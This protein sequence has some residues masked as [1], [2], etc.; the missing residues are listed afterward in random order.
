MRRAEP[1]SA[2]L[3]VMA[4]VGFGIG[5]PLSRVAADL[6][7]NAATITFWRAATSVIALALLLGVGVLLRRT[8]TT[9]WASISRLE[10][11]QLVA[12]GV[13][14][15]GTTLG[16]YTALERISVALAYILFYTYPTIVALAAVRLYG[17]P[18]PPARLAAISMATLGMVLVV[19]A[20][21][22]DGARAGVDVVGILLAFGAGLCQAGYAL[23]AARGFASVPTF[24][25]STLLRAFSVVVYAVLL[26][27]LILALGDLDKL[28]GPLGS[29]EA[30][31]VVGVAGLVTAALPTT[32]LVAGY[33]RVGPTR[34]AVLMLFEPLVGVLLAAV[35]LAEQPTPL[36]LVGGLMV[37]V[38]GAVVQVTASR[39]TVETVALSAD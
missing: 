16:I 23:V 25:A 35:W 27:P 29:P 12:M 8:N 4:A 17:E 37:L 7:F 36:Q 24:Q 1:F 34:G 6:G 20:P 15:A 14:V 22:A 28:V 18:L 5:A 31:I 30:W 19:V 33:R 9:P 32:F 2:G 39:S 26:L 13:F 11:V 21:D 10:R 38:G 3:V